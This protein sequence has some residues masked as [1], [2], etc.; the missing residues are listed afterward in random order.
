MRSGATLTVA[1]LNECEPPPDIVKALRREKAVAAG[2]DEVIN[3]QRNT[4]RR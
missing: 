4:N 3:L 1:G 2:L